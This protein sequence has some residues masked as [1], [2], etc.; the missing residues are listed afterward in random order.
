MASL[1]LDPHYILI[2]VVSWSSLNLDPYCILTHVASWSTL[3]LEPCCILIHIASC[4]TLHLHPFCI[5]NIDSIS[6]FLVLQCAVRAFPNESAQIHRGDQ[7]AKGSGPDSKEA[8]GGERG[9]L[10]LDIWMLLKTRNPRRSTLGDARFQTKC[11]CS[12]RNWNAWRKQRRLLN[13]GAIW[14]QFCY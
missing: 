13:G 4:S 5:Y 2:L 14:I 10:D 1:H 12:R 9:Y 6:S 3:H 8:R 7:D 11:E